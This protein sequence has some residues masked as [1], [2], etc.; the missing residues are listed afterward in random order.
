MSEELLVLSSSL[1]YHEQHG[2][3]YVYHNRVGYLL[4]MSLDVLQFLEAFREPTTQDAVIEHFDGTYP[5]EMVKDFVQTFRAHLCI[6]G[7]EENE[8]RSLWSM[9][10][11]HSRWVVFHAPEDRSEAMRFYHVGPDREAHVDTLE[12]WE[13]TL[14]ERMDGDKSLSALFALTRAHE[15]LRNDPDPAKRVLATISRWVHVDLQ[16]ARL[17]EYPVSMYKQQ[18]HLR[19]P[20]LSSVMP[21]R[22]YEMGDPPTEPLE[23]LREIVPT[24]YYREEIVD[25]KNQF[26]D[27]ETTLSHLFREPHPALGGKTYG[28]RMAEALLASDSLPEKMRDIVEVGGGLGFF[29]SAFL[30]E[31]SARAPQRTR[32]LRYRIVDLSPVLQAAQKERLGGHA[33]TISFSAGNAETLELDEA[34][35]DLVLC[36]EVVGDLTGVRVTRAQLG[37]DMPQDESMLASAPKGSLYEGNEDNIRALGDVGELVLKYELPLIDAPEDCYLNVGLFRF[38][39]RLWTALRPGGTAVITEFGEEHQYPALSLHLDH[40]ELSIHFGHAKHVARRIGFDVEFSYVID[41]LGFER[42]LETLA[43]TRS[44]FLALRALLGEKGVDLKKLA[45]TKDMLTEVIGDA[46]PL[47]EI[48]TLEFEAIENRCLGLVPHQFKA[49]VLRKPTGK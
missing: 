37:L 2:A 20:Y 36:N 35:V 43:C 33:N 15:G 46:V 9:F 4:R 30:G 7:A 11:M 38:L 25:A 44:S 28:A 23:E 19:Q 18:P 31:V 45:Y 27:V 8:G 12:D 32:D 24:K 42:D 3:Y 26:D 21:Y 1:S 48:G 47:A 49:L 17:S 13:R 39:E 41:L 40:P 22:R 29:A 6:L 16:A 5:A 10:P 34:S 14:W